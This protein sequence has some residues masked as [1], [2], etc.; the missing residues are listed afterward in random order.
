MLA[1]NATTEHKLRFFKG[2]VSNLYVAHSLTMQRNRDLVN[3]KIPSPSVFL[4]RVHFGLAVHVCYFIFLKGN[5]EGYSR[6]QPKTRLGGIAK[7]TGILL[8]LLTCLE[9]LLN[10]NHCCSCFEHAA[11][12]DAISASSTSPACLIVYHRQLYAV[13]LSY[14]LV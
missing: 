6:F 14:F 3:C 13:L 5:I 7:S 9:A 12:M 10:Y 1:Q 11:F 4:R 2:I 8:I